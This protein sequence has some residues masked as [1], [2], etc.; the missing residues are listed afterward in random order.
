MGGKYFSKIY[1]GSSL[2]QQCT[3]LM[4]D[5]MHY[6]EG[7]ENDFAVFCFMYCILA[8]ILKGKLD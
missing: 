3:Y 5:K 7:R 4:G 6:K 1:I 8:K 2:S